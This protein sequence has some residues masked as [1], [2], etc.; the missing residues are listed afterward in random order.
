M[1]VAGKPV[2]SG[3]MWCSAFAHKGGKVESQLLA[4]NTRCLTLRSGYRQLIAG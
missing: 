1:R 3:F 4:R 2:S